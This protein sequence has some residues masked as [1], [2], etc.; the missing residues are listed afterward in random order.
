MPD[1][2]LKKLGKHPRK[3]AKLLQLRDY[4]QLPLQV[5]ASYGLS[6]KITDLGEMLNDKLGDCTCAAVGHLIQA[7]TAEAGHQ[8]IVSDDTI[9]KLYEDS[10]GY[11][12]ADPSTDQGGI[13][14]DVLNYWIKNPVAGNVL[15]AY[16][17][18][19]HMDAQQIK[20]SVF[21]FGGAYIG[22]QLPLAYQTAEV[23]NVVKGP[24]GV[25]GSW[26][27]HAVPIV[28]YNSGGPIVISWGEKIQMTWGAVYKYVDESYALL[29][30]DVFMGTKSITGLSIGQLRRDLIQL[31][32]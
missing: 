7:W 9:L 25:P 13:E 11:N 32:S 1:R 19:N 26:G 30:P 14:V 18:F 17:S 8:V 31:N 6:D 22:L 21:Y 3:H 4:A 24:N 28:D 29:S 5:P 20:E 12:P 15:S 27:G 2:S 16:V 10:C 23:W